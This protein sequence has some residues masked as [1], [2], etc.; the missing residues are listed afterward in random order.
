LSSAAFPTFL[1]RAL[2]VTLLIHNEER[3]WDRLSPRGA[4]AT[5]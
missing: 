1:F 5:N 2:F 4:R 3:P